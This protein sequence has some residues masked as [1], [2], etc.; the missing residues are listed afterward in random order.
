MNGLSTKMGHT[1]INYFIEHCDYKVI[2]IGDEDK[3]INKEEGNI[4]DYTKFKS[5]KEK[6]IGKTFEIKSNI[7]EAFETFVAK[8]E[9]LSYREFLSRNRNIIVQIH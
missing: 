1:H 2:L 5:I 3:I 7:D 8:S 6:L 4:D 9:H